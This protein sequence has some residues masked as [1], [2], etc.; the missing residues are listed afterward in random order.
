MFFLGG[1]VFFEKKNM[2]FKSLLYSLVYKNRKHVFLDAVFFSI[3]NKNQ[4]S[5]YI[6]MQM[7]LYYIV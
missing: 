5:I 7:V 1:R 6:S 2:F 4:K 3:K